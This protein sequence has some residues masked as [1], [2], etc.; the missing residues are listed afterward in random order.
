MLVEANLLSERRAEPRRRVLSRQYLN[1]Q[2]SGRCSVLVLLH[3]AFL[4]QYRYARL[5]QSGL[6]PY[7][8]EL[9]FRATSPSASSSPLRC[10]CVRLC[11]YGDACWLSVV[12]FSL[13]GDVRGEVETMRRVLQARRWPAQTD[14][15]RT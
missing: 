9:T 11:S 10:A 4:H 5:K 13:Y 7:V 15:V 14:Y 8:S 2:S 3:L 12:P 1:Q 6:M